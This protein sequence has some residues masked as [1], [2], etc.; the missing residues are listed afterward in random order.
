MKW[1]GGPGVPLVPGLWGPPDSRWL[2]PGAVGRGE[3]G[4][5][6]RPTELP[7]QAPAAPVGESLVPTTLPTHPPPAAPGGGGG[8]LGQ[9]FI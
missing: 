4:G 9:E 3:R 7:L 1:W 6:N 2:V 8:G 5:R